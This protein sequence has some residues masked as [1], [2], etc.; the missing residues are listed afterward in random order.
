M[1]AIVN[2]V[3]CT[4]NELRNDCV[5][6]FDDKV[7]NIL[8][9]EEFENYKV[10]NSVE[11]IDANN[12]FVLAG[13]IDVHIHGFN[14]NDTM[15]CTDDGL[16]QIQKDLVKNGVTT[17]LPTTMTMNIDTIKMALDKVERV[18][19]NEDVV[20]AEI[21]GVHL[22]GPFISAKYKGAQS[23]EFIISPDFDLIEQYK[24]LIKVVTIAPEIEN[25]Q[26]LIEMY[27]EEINF[28]I[29]HTNAT[30]EQCN[31]A[32]EHGAVSFTHLF[33]AMTPM[34]H[35]EIGAVGSALTNDTYAE[36]I[37]DKFHVSPQ[38]YDM[39]VKAK[40]VDKILLI[41][42]CI[43]AGGL[44]DGVYNLG[45]QDV[46]V[47]NGRCLLANGTIAGSTLNLNEALKNFTECSSL[48]LIES[49]RMVTSNQA[50]Y[51]KIDDEVGSLD[52]GKKANIVIMDK[53]FDVIKTI[54]KG[55]VVY[56]V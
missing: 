42:D 14:N 39:L 30:A 24:H 36:L 25:A 17:F 5:I 37:A 10:D 33:N 11:I 49:I 52:I 54:V 51:L 26:K 38:L 28:S 13:F 15:D 4:K 23:D 8:T 56:E 53:S 9:C 6:V 22:E 18:M 19:K 7:N 46:N 27:G 41:T 32:I 21:A 12:N 55:V 40:G 43:R 20:G 2:G 34:S 16:I 44:K 31:E 1:K 45:G 35:R 29:G 48:T 3:V 47:S 50:E